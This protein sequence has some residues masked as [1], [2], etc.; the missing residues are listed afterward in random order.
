MNREK[1][2]GRRDFLRAA[3]VA[4]AGGGAWLA[5]ARPGAEAM[6]WQIDPSKCTQC[7][8]CATDCVLNPSA[9]KCVH[10]HE[11]CGY[12]DL[13]GGYLQ[14]GAKEQDTGAE[15]ELCPVA[16][17]Q[18]KFIEDPFF[19][20]T[21]DEPLCVGCG[22]CVRGCGQFGNGSLYLQ[23]KRDLCADCNECSFARNCPSQAISL[24]PSRV[25]YLLK[26][27]SGAVEPKKCGGFAR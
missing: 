5:S 4:A 15:N 20:Y 1:G 8:R 17:I 2:F 24:V 27:A 23:I 3:A 11:I 18:R 13:C 6:V 14:P 16:A 21:I 26:N 9:V 7:G 12:C 22:K 19:E 25:G 10:S